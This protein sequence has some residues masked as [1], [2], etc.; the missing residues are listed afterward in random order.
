[1]TLDSKWEFS[2]REALLLAAGGVAAT[3]APS[4]ARA[5]AASVS[6]LVFE[7]KDG[8]GTARPRQPGPRRRA[9]LQRQ[10]RRGH[11]RRRALP[12]PLPEEAAIFVV[13][14]AGFMPPVDPVD[15]PAAVLS[16]AS[17]GGIAGLAESHLRGRRR[18][19]APCPLR[20]ISRCAGRT[21]PLRSRS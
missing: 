21:N 9:R 15:Q 4:A 18:R 13:K 16:A 17:T 7:D 8:A 6:G 14:P 2:R 1:M 12:L 10:G 19:P 3:L 11:R 20:S 5:G